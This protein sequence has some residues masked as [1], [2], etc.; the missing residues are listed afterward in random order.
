MLNPPSTPRLQMLNHAG[1]QTTGLLS[2]EAYP[3]DNVR[4][5]AAPVALAS[6][7]LLS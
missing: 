1:D 5:A 4:C 6:G 3:A 2:D 7:L